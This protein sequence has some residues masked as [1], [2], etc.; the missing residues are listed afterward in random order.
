MI[1]ILPLINAS[2]EKPTQGN[3][4]D[5]RYSHSIPSKVSSLVSNASFK[6]GMQRCYYFGIAPATGKVDSKWRLFWG[7]I[8]RGNGY[9]NKCPSKRRMRDLP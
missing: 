7:V 5:S 1:F 4:C 8:G 3:G 2:S 9:A 6:S